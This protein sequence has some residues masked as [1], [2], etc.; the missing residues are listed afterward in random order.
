MEM[1]LSLEPGFTQEGI[2]LLSL[3]F[4]GSNSYVRRL[5]F[6]PDF[7]QAMRFLGQD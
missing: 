7:V 4:D 6:N 1:F 5:F 2:N 3:E